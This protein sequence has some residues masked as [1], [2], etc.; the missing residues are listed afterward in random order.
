[1]NFSVCFLEKHAVS[2][3][4]RVVLARIFL[5]HA[6]LAFVHDQRSAPSL[7]SQLTLIQLV[8]HRFVH[9]NTTCLTPLTSWNTLVVASVPLLHTCSHSPRDYAQV[10]QR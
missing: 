10:M 3:W 2:L 5:S 1:M 6:T 4:S 8:L 9:K 7:S